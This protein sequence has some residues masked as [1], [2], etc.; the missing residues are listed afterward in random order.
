MQI[1]V[2][3]LA[4]SV[5]ICSLYSES[6]CQ[7]FY[8][9]NKAYFQQD[10]AESV[11]EYVKCLDKP[12]YALH[13]NMGSSYFKLGNLGKAHY[14][15]LKAQQLNPHHP[16]LKFNLS[17]VQEQLIDQE[18]QAFL[19]EVN[20][21]GMF[22]LRILFWLIFASCI[23]FLFRKKIG[24]NFLIFGVLLVCG[25]T[26]YHWN[27]LADW[28]SYGVVLGGKQVIYSNQNLHSSALTEVHAGK[29]L[30]IISVHKGWLRVSVNPGL[31]GWIP[32]NNLGKL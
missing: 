29:L 4:F 26:W 5:L 31:Q 18:S 28:Q 12:T 23:G 24:K 16:N 14:H 21:Q 25:W 30:N 15:F 19:D 1:K 3:F 13:S 2:L 9:G 32:D 20:N 17:L 6:G 10:Y 22:E 27:K 8:E 11:I 7:G